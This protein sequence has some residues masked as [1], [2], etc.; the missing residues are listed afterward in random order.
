MRMKKLSKKD[1]SLDDEELAERLRLVALLA[2]DLEGTP[3][4]WSGLASLFELEDEVRN[5]GFAQYFFN[6]SCVGALDAWLLAREVAP[7]AA[8]ALADA[9][10][11]LGESAGQPIDFEARLAAAGVGGLMPELEIL[12]RIQ[13]EAHAASKDV[14]T[15]F[16]R[17]RKACAKTRKG[18]LGFE[19][20]EERFFEQVDLDAAAVAYVRKNPSRFIW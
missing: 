1:L 5:G 20:L 11:R 3:E 16:T 17:F 13:R 9:A 18:L 6:P 12:V 2:R 19:A 4:G 10:R 14:M 7:L 15:A 8:T